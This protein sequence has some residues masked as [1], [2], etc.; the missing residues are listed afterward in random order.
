M[1]LVPHPISW[2]QFSELVGY[3]PEQL[4]GVRAGRRG[5]TI[6]LLVEDDMQTRGTYAQLHD[7]TDRRTPAR[8]VKR[9]PA[10]KTTR[11]PTR[12]PGKR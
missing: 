1:A 5:S 3:P 6:T 4:A 11:T 10:R 9:K 2:S 12:R 8:P 7:N